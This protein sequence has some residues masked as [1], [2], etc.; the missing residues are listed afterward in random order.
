MTFHA[1]FAGICTAL[2]LAACA[3]PAPVQHPH[4]H[5]DVL[6]STDRGMHGVA[7][8]TEHTYLSLA[9]S[10][11]ETSAVM[12][13]GKIVNRAS[14]WTQVELGP[15]SLGPA[16]PGEALRAPSLARLAGGI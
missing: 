10:L 16:A 14:I 6:L 9:N 8:D 2:T 1:A 3:A 4:G 15:C 13:S 7:F 11:N 5:T 12:R